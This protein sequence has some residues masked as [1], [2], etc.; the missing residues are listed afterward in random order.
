MIAIVGEAWGKE[1]AEAGLPFVGPSGRFLSALMAQVGIDRKHCLIT[2]V[3]N[4]RPSPDSNDL[5]HLCGPKS[6]AIPGYPA[7]IK[8][9][10]VRAEFKPELDRLAKELSDARPN[11]IIALGNTALW[12][13]LRTTGLKRIRGTTVPSPFG[14][15]LAT[16]HPAAILREWS[17][18]TILLADLR[19]CVPESAF[20]DIRRPHREVWIEPT[21]ADLYEFERQYIIPSPDLSIDIETKWDQITEIGFAPSI[22]RALVVPFYDRSKPDGNYW[23]TVREEVKALMWVKHICALRK[24][25]V[26]Q[27]LLYDMNFLWTQYNIPVPFAEED[28]MLCQHALFP[29]LEKGLGFLGSIHTSEPSWKLMR[30]VETRKRED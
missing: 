10:F 14:K 12:A 23:P 26:G 6:E 25:I 30:E 3:F 16:Y 22:D 1:E 29:E 21:L 15:V 17:L 18:R 11:L 2:N 13:L 27:N 9:K 5:K 24:R 20:P 7:L 19:K 8:G 28:T 4:R